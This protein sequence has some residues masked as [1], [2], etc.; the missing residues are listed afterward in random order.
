MYVSVAGA[1]FRRLL[2]G[3]AGGVSPCP[4]APPA[5]GGPPGL[6]SVWKLGPNRLAVRETVEVQ[7]RM[8][9]RPDLSTCTRDGRKRVR[10]RGEE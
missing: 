8:M 3:T 9:L 10:S 6:L 1:E 4:A 5:M 2:L 7:E